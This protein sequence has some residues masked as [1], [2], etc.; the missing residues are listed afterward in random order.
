MMKAQ[1]FFDYVCPFCYL[2]RTPLHRALQKAGIQWEECPFEL[3]RPPTPKVDPM[4][5]AMRLKRWEEVLRPTAQKMG[6]PMSL[7]YISPHPY[8][9]LAFLGYAY[10]RRHQK[11]E[12][13][14]EKVFHAFYAK[15]QD[16]G[17][18]DVLLPIARE[19]GLDPDDFARS[20]REQEFL[21]ELDE[22]K[23]YAVSCGVKNIPSIKL[24][25]QMITGLHTEDEYLSLLREAAG[26]AAPAFTCG[27]DGCGIPAQKEEMP[28]CG[29]D[30][31]HI[32]Q[33]EDTPSCG[34]D[35]CGMPAR[36]E[37][38]PSCGPD[39]CSLSPHS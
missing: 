34:P 26:E 29:P 6:I 2:A 17:E 27:P 10:A 18:L 37:D 35:G 31:C 32:P 22:A 25:N 14:N 13:Y 7:P 33:R 15:E 24:G 19:L 23:A 11:G 36:N 4:H 21:P 28:S 38:T 1:I 5:D 16:I 20:L 8:T 30:G 9:T 3:R 12:A 39:G